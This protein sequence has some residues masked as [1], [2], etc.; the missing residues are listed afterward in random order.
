MRTQTVGDRKFILDILLRFFLSP[1]SQKKGA[2]YG[3]RVLCTL[4]IWY[5]RNRVTLHS[6]LICYKRDR[7]ALRTFRA[8]YERNRVRLRTWLFWYEGHGAKLCNMRISYKGGGLGAD[9]QTAFFIKMWRVP[10][11]PRPGLVPVPPGRCRLP[12]TASVRRGSGAAPE[13]CGERSAGSSARTERGAP[14]DGVAA[15]QKARKRGWQ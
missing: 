5:E 9:T 10:A 2:G 7:V 14:R 13:K 15:A 6:L 1:I 4:L 3:E 8:C 11:A 12:R